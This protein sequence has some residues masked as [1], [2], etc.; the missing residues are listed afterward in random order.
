M[1]K[2]A[3]RVTIKTCTA[4]THIDGQF[5]VQPDGRTIRPMRSAVLPFRRCSAYTLAE[6]IMVLLIISLLL[7]MPQLNLVGMLR[8]NTFKANVQELISTMQMAVN[9]AA[10]SDRRYEVI[11]D[12]A[13]Q[14]YV[15]REI[16]SPDLSEVLE[17]DIISEKYFSDN[18]RVEYVLFDD[19]VFTNETRAMFRAGHAGWQSGGIIVLL[20]E[21]EQAYTVVVNKL[22]K[23]ITLQQ[24]EVEP[25][26]LKSED[27]VPF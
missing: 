25:L 20:D 14:G 7:L 12:I 9:A 1:V 4:Q 5:F 27:E 16:T 11:I 24:G 21:N 17:E 8:K 2:K 13:E 22:N 18:C 10:E 23:V 6:I 15:L 26:A 3:V 19:G